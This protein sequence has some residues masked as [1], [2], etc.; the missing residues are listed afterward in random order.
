MK[1]EREGEPVPLKNIVLLT[2][3]AAAG[4]GCQSNPSSGDDSQTGDRLRVVAEGKNTDLVFKAD[5]PGTIIVN[6]FSQGGNLYT[7][8]LNGGD[9]F[10]LTPNADHAT[11][12]KKEVPLDHDTNPVST[13]R[14]YFFPD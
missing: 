2:L 1:T 4:V 6:N 14:L 12:G 8:H 5:K 9:Q 10:T 3:L 11:I 13:Y 7:G